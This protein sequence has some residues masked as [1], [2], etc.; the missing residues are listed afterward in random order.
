MEEGRGTGERRQLKEAAAEGQGASTASPS[1]R[2]ERSVEIHGYQYHGELDEEGVRRGC[3]RPHLIPPSPQLPASHRP[4][5]DGEPKPRDAPRVAVNGMAD[6][7]KAALR[8]G[9]W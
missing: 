8:E 2:S 5:Q 9:G 3:S 1:C 6:V 7:L 4:H